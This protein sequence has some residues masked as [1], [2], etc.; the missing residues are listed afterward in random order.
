MAN[1]PNTPIEAPRNRG[2]FLLAGDSLRLAKLTIEIGADGQAKG[3]ASIQ[4]GRSMCPVW[5]RVA[6]GHIHDAAAAE[7]RLLNAHTENNERELGLALADQARSGMQA[8]VASCAAFD[9]FYASILERVP[10]EPDTLAAWRKNRTGRYRQIAETLRRIF[11]TSTENSAQ[12]RTV[13]KDS[14]LYRSW[15]V[16]PPSK[17]REPVHYPEI[18]RGVEWSLYAFR[19]HNAR[20]ITG[21]TLSILAQLSVRNRRPP[22]LDDFCKAT[23]SQLRELVLN[24]EPTF[25]PI[26]PKDFPRDG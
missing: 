18:E 6:I 4:V 26:V 23:S 7:V 9:A 10:I 13:L 25:G 14:F 5:L 19:L 22:R 15:A 3:S 24:W 8:I 1:D 2:V 11:K 17:W 16:H 21:V 20:T 12:I